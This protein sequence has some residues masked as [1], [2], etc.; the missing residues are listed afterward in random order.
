MLAPQ[1]S[2]IAAQQSASVCALLCG[3]QATAGAAVQN[4]TAISINH[5]TFL[6]DVMMQS[7]ASLQE[8]ERW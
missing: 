2:S 4:R 6:P 1:F 3:R 5:A 8:N 7:P